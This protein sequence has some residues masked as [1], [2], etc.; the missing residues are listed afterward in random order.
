[1]KLVYL[2]NVDFWINFHVK[3]KYATNIFNALCTKCK[4][5]IPAV[6]TPLRNKINHFLLNMH[7]SKKQSFQLKGKKNDWANIIDMK[8]LNILNFHKTTILKIFQIILPKMC[9]QFIY[10]VY[11]VSKIKIYCMES[12]IKCVA[13]MK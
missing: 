5:L 1:M 8:K 10:L 4:I 2:R 6:Y 13:N 3:H 9:K 12:Y 7:I 11:I